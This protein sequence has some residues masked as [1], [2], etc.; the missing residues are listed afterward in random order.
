MSYDF[1]RRDLLVTEA[2][3]V[4]ILPAAS[5][6]LAGLVMIGCS[7]STDA[8]TQR[9]EY[10]LE[11]ALEYGPLVLDTQTQLQ[12]TTK[13]RRKKRARG[14]REG[15]DATIDQR[16]TENE[17]KPDLGKR[18]YRRR[19]RELAEPHPTRNPENLFKGCIL[20]TKEVSV[21]PN[22]RLQ[23]SK[24][25]LSAANQGD[26]REQSHASISYPSWLYV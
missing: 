1:R 24:A 22:A 14:P 23:T 9:E 11:Y 18:R 2:G 4:V 12:A 13:E 20:K 5:V 17:I 6:A 3:C 7:A 16:N 10:A 15:D 25:S 21:A 8:D 19:R 26:R